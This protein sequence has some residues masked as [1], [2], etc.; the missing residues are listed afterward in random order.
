MP[1]EPMSFEEQTEVL[2][3]I[4]LSFAYVLSA[5]QREDAVRLLRTH[6]DQAATPARAGIVLRQLADAIRAASAQPTQH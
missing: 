4:V 3:G 2:L 6:A 1:S 5:D